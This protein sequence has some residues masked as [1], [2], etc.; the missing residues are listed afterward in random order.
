MS[1]DS[2]SGLH[3]WILLFPNNPPGLTLL[4]PHFSS[5]A[6]EDSEMLVTCPDSGL[7]SWLGVSH[8]V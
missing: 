4:L 6:I 8:G 7:W 3:A 5:E 2:V 1:A